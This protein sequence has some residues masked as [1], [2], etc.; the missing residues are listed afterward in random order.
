[1]DKPGLIDKEPGNIHDPGAVEPLIKLLKA[2][3]E[4]KR[5]K[6]AAALGKIGDARAVEP[7]IDVLKDNIPEVREKAF[8]ALAEIGDGSALWPL[9]E[10][11]KAYF[12]DREDLS[13]VF[14]KWGA[15][16]FDKEHRANTKNTIEKICRKVPVKNFDFFC[17]KCFCRY[18][19]HWATIYL[20]KGFTYYA[21]RNCHYNSYWL[22]GIKKVVLLLDH[23]FKEM[24]VQDGGTL[25]VNWYTKKEPFDFDEI[26][27]TGADDYDV[28]VLVMKLINDMDKKRRKRLA[29]IP[30]YLSPNLE[31]SRAKMNMLNDNFRIVKWIKKKK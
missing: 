7:L 31:L 21:C 25:T 12:P 28:E 9:T 4:N 16:I 3:D 24:F 27:I 18:R 14:N 5:K 8:E 30:V 22:I 11:R 26:R 13:E 15:I 29:K 20:L 23:N 2:W 19:K 10:L 17:R 1:V 6:A